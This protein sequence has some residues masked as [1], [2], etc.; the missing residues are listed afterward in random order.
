MVG[1]QSE[2]EGTFWVITAM[3][4]G[5]AADLADKTAREFTFK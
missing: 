5:E 4:T 2:T 3:G 1:I